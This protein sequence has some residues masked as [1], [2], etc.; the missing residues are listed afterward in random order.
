[1]EK[2]LVSSSSIDPGTVQAY[3]ET[4]YRVSGDS[5][6]ILRVGITCPELAVLHSAHGANCSAFITAYNPYSRA[7]GEADNKA[8]QAKLTRE[9]QRGGLHFID[10]LGQHPSNQWPGE[11]SFLVFNLALDSAKA[12]GVRFEQNALIWSGADAVPQLILLR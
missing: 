4:E 12:L 9:F 7:L 2:D 1:M 6:A 10:G 5:P 11:P 8:F 3:L